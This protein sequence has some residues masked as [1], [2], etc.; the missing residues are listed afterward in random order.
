MQFRLILVMLVTLDV[1]VRR[2]ISE[3]NQAETFRPILWGF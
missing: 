2:R 3:V 1:G